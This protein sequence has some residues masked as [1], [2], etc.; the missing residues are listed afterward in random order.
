[1]KHSQWVW[2]MAL[3][4]AVLIVFSTTFAFAQSGGYSL[5]WFSIDNGGGQSIGGAYALNGVIG[6][7]EAGAL[8]GG[9][10]TL[11]GGFLQISDYRVYLPT[12]LR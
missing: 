8:S 3:L 4:I 11:N 6:Q 1:M 9:A 12:V 10:Y 7:A 5:D 2:G